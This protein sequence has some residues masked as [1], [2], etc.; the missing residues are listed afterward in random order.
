[1]RRQNMTA[2]HVAK[3]YAKMAAQKIYLPAIYRKY[4]KLPVAA[5]LRVWI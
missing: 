4:V 1:M 2:R 3:Q 5:I